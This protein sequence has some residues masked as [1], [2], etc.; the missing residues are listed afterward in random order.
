MVAVTVAILPDFPTS[1]QQ[2]HPGQ[3]NFQDATTPTIY[4]IPIYG[5]MELLD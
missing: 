5:S 3:L 4:G 2:F 1:R